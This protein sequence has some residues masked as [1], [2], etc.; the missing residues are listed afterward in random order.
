[1]VQYNLVGI[2]ARSPGTLGFGDCWQQL[3]P[4]LLAPKKKP[5]PKRSVLKIGPRRHTRQS[6]AGTSR[7]YLKKG[8]RL[9]TFHQFAGRTGNPTVLLDPFF[10]YFSCC[11]KF[12]VIKR[13]LKVTVVAL[14]AVCHPQHVCCNNNKVVF[15]PESSDRHGTE[16]NRHAARP[17][18]DRN[19]RGKKEAKANKRAGEHTASSLTR[20]NKSHRYR[21]TTVVFLLLHEEP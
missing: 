17:P 15:W 16:R 2:T 3:F 12:S 19:Q 8:K 21:D 14:T 9:L 7:L 5:K 10:S 4:L 20:K 1:M 18:A 6:V 13:S 11:F